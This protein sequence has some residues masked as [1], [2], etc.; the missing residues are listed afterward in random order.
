MSAANVWL[1]GFSLI[2]G[3]TYPRHHNSFF[4]VEFATN[5]ADKALHGDVAR[6]E[7]KGEHFATPG[8]VTRLGVGQLTAPN[9]VAVSESGDVFVTDCSSATAVPAVRM[10]CCLILY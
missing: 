9:D 5:P 8:R 1:G 7:V 10:S 6:V 4:V 3:I 2:T